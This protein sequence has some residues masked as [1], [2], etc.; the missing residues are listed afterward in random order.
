[1]GT[2]RAGSTPRAPVPRPASTPASTS[3]GPSGSSNGGQPSAATLIDQAHHKDTSTPRKRRV[4]RKRSTEEIVQK[5]LLDNFKGWSHHDIDVHQVDGKSLRCRLADDKR[6]QLSGAPVVM[7]ASYYK[8][9]KE[10]Y[11]N[12]GS[13]E[14][15]LQVKDNS[16]EVN[17]RLQKALVAY[18]SANSNKALL[19][20]YLATA[21]GINQKELVGLFRCACAL[22][23]SV[24]TRSL[25]LALDLM[26]FAQRLK[27][28]TLFAEE[29]N[30]MRH[31]FDDTLLAAFALL[32]K[33]QVSVATFWNL[34]SDICPLVLNV[35]DVQRLVSCK[36]KW[37]DVK[38]ELLRVTGATKVGMRMFGFAAQLVLAQTVS[39]K[40]D[41]ELKKLEGVA[42]TQ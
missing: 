10:L 41:A 17:P 21:K 32:K 23:P 9:L 1:M 4:L 24:S 2:K 12:A 31:L 20:E 27:L 30:I 19:T 8:N 25:H 16:L 40:I 18:R 22:K 35:D 3:P 39:D 14:K 6:A 34:Y 36:T 37:T 15:R 29:V 38:E 33:E 28:S 7:G 42:I 13:P 5:A 26:R 11:S